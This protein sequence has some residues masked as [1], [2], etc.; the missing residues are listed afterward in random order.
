MLS[1]VTGTRCV[2]FYYCTR[3]LL[4]E[5]ILVSYF[6]SP[7]LKLENAKGLSKDKV[8]ELEK[9]VQ[10]M[11]VDLVGEVYTCRMVEVLKL[12]AHR[13]GVHYCVIP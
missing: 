7:L 4:I 1:A 8:L 10:C 6:R 5:I 2:K 12:V 9:E 13:T 11:A 3:N